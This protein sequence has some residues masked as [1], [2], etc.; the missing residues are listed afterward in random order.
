[1]K[2]KPNTPSAKW[3]KRSG[4]SKKCSRNKVGGLCPEHAAFGTTGCTVVPR[5]LLQEPGGHQLGA[6]SSVLKRPTHIGP[7]TNHFVARTRAD[8]SVKRL[9]ER[10]H[11]CNNLLITKIG[12]ASCRERV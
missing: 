2:A 10:Q 4:R 3:K 1:M 11:D 7:R 9:N 6:R 8:V 5:S 12:R